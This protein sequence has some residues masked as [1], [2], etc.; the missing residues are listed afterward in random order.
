[1]IKVLF[2]IIAVLLLFLAVFIFGML[3]FRNNKDEIESKI[4]KTN[5][6]I[7]DIKKL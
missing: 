6:I 1:M 2:I 3:V 5:E 7:D 4:D